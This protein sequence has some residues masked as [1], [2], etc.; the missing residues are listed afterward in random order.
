MN[1]CGLG[2]TDTQNDLT[3]VYERS[4]LNSLSCDRRKSLVKVTSHHQSPPGSV[5]ISRL[6]SGMGFGVTAQSCHTCFRMI[7]LFNSNLLPCLVQAC[8]CF[9][10]RKHLE[11][12]EK[13]FI[14]NY[15]QKFILW[16]I[17]FCP[18]LSM[19]W[20][21]E[22]YGHTSLGIIAYQPFLWKIYH[23]PY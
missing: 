9:N 19:G 17:T 6:L 22:F 5:F 15:F 11:Q 12:D 8:T 18:I 7:L 10:P 21:I 14:F 1:H 13:Q 16:H 23:Q 3:A 4:H 20:E 2:E